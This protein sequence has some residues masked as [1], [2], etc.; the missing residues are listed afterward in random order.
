LNPLPD[1]SADGHISLISGGKNSFDSFRVGSKL[2]QAALGYALP[3]VRLK[4]TVSSFQ[5]FCI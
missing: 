3:G 4:L 2:E 1:Q 5:F